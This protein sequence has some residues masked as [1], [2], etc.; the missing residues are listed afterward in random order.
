MSEYWIPTA[1]LLSA[2]VIGVC[3]LLAFIVINMQSA[4]RHRTFGLLG[5]AMM[6]ACTMLQALNGSLAG[7]YGRNTVVYDAVSIMVGVL[8]ASGVVLMALAVVQARRSR[9][10]SDH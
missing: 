9:R 10:A 3:F 5:V 1:R 7:A 6:L 4:G 8:A 2:A